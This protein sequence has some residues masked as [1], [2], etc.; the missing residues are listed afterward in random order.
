MIGLALNRFT[1]RLVERIIP[2][3]PV[4]GVC[5]TM[6]LVAGGAANSVSSFGVDLMRAI[7]TSF[8]YP[9]IG[10]GLALAF[11]QLV[12]MSEKSR[13]TLVVETLSKSPTLAYVLARTHFGLEA[14]AIPAAAMVSLALVGALVASLWAALDNAN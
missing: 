10:G 3:C 12:T 2:S 4:I 8:I 1:P 14:A 5:A 6:I 11:S 7:V 9:V 13:R